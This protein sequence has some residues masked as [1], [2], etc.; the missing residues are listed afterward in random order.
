[1]TPALG[2]PG[3][4]PR[5]PMAKRLL[6][7]VRWIMVG[8]TI[9]DF[10]LTIDRF[11]SNGNERETRSCLRLHHGP[12]SEKARRGPKGNRQ[13]SY[14]RSG[15]HYKLANLDGLYEAAKAMGKLSV[16]PRAG[17]F[18]PGIPG[19]LF[20]LSGREPIET[21]PRRRFAKFGGPDRMRTQRAAVR[22]ASLVEQR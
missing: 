15:R 17:K 13:Q 9:V 5:V 3:L 8:L 6:T 22:S 12:A 16:T 19:N 4:V 21:S 18:Q 1:M 20:G 2:R 11:Q 7:V 10:V 14:W